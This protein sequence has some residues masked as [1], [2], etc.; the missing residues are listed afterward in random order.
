VGVGVG[1]RPRKTTEASIFIDLV[2]RQ[3]QQISWQGVAVAEVN[4]KVATQLR[5]A[6][7]TSVNR[8]YDRYPHRAA[9]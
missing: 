1:S 9:P 6:V 3:K 7:F 8:I 5:D 4:D 2:D